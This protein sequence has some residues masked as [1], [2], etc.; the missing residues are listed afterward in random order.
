M[1]KHITLWL[2]KKNTLQWSCFKCHHNHNIRKLALCWG[3][4]FLFFYG[5][6]LGEIIKNNEQVCWQHVHHRFG[7]MVP[8]SCSSSHVKVAYSR[9]NLTWLGLQSTHVKIDYHG[10]S[11]VICRTFKW[12][13][14]M[15]TAE[16]DILRGT[17]SHKFGS[18]CKRGLN[19]FIIWLLLVDI[20]TNFWSW[21][22]T[23]I[24]IT[25]CFISFLS[26]K[27]MNSRDY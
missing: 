21:I 6:Y 8:V 4:F 26:L 18:L 20:S 17:A 19:T 2:I 25:I 11:H 10:L 14:G 15:T 12:Y 16:G 27:L 1:S 9:E 24:L 5:P 7:S 13:V 23:W 3:C 22:K